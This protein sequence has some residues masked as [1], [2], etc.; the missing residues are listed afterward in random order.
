[1]ENQAEN[2]VK[3]HTSIK[4][5]GALFNLTHSMQIT[6]VKKPA[7]AISATREFYAAGCPVF[8]KFVRFAT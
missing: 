3:H 1:L 7:T 5:S 2:K 8:S 6:G 4:R